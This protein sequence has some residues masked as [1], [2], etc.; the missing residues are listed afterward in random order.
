MSFSHRDPGTSETAWTQAGARN[1]PE[2]A[3]D[4]ISDDATIVVLAAHPDD[5]ALGA[6]SLLA[7]LRLCDRRAV[8]ILFTAGESSHPDSPSHS[9]EELKTVR[10]R[11]FH[12]AL[13]ALGGVSSRF[14]GLPDGRL[15]EFS[16]SIA[17]EITKAVG[18]CRGPV[19]LVAPY[20]RDGHGDHET[21]G[22]AALQVGHA[23]Q[24]IVLEYPIW[25][26]HWAEPSDDAW[27]SW[28]FLP[29]PAHLDRRAV[30]DCYQSQVTDLSDHPG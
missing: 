15:R 4:V 3:R 28:S 11:E 19:V 26:W 20:S 17:R 24:T 23:T 6:A 21:V 2:L 9:R 29:D 12:S 16:D 18:Q 1:L 10:L 22:A 25:F 30:F 14:V 7:R 8:V 13:E 5:E 27:R